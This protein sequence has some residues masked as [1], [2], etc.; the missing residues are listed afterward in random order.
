MVEALLLFV[1]ADALSQNG[2]LQS[3]D[4][5]TENT[6]S[7]SRSPLTKT[8]LE[9]SATGSPVLTGGGACSLAVLS[10]ACRPDGGQVAV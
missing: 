4:A 10:A 1:H 3:A 2:T 7:E 8:R 6:E 5:A 9:A